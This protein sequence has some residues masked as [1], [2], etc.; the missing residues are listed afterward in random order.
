MS[1][2]KFV[3][4]SNVNLPFPYPMASANAKSIWP[5]NEEGF[6]LIHATLNQTDKFVMI[7]DEAAIFSLLK[8][9]FFGYNSNK[10]INHFYLI[11]S[12]N[13]EARN[14]TQKPSSNFTLGF[15]SL[16]QIDIPEACSK[17]E[18]DANINE[19]FE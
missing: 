9:G 7:N 19:V 14:K 5:F 17:F 16:N 11:E 13:L 8:M 6:V 2:K 1:V 12:M 3:N 10:E 4:Q 15:Y 18:Q